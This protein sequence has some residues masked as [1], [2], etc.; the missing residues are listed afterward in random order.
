MKRE[1]K[2]SEPPTGFRHPRCY[3]SVDADCS[4]K[5]SREHF[6]S[7]SLLRK[8][9]LYKKAKI[10]GLAWQEPESFDLV[11]VKGLASN[12]LC[13]RHNSSLS[14]RDGLIDD[15]ATAIRAFDCAPKS[16]HVKFSGSDLER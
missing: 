1:N 3:A 9:E 7:A 6:I 13:E 14:S 11:P 2:P 8:L 5:I 4:T 15:F 12:I 10:A 16:K